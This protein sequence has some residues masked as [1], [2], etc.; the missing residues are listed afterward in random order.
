MDQS[1]R[2]ASDGCIGSGLLARHR[3]RLDDAVHAALSDAQAGEDS[4]LA[5]IGAG[6]VQDPHDPRHPR[7]HAGSVPHQ[8]PAGI[9][10]Q[11]CRPRR[12]AD[13][14][15]ERRDRPLS[16]CQGPQRAIRQHCRG[17]RDP[18][19]CRRA[20][21]RPRRRTSECGAADRGAAG[22][23]GEGAGASPELAG[24]FLVVSDRWRPY[25]ARPTPAAS[26]CQED[27]GLRSPGGRLELVPE[28]RAVEGCPG[29]ADLPS[30][31][32]SRRHGLRSPRACSRNW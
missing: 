14:R 26:A 5:G 6:L 9:A 23:R 2:R 13:R 29:T 25:R 1:R 15:G 27:R 12:H 8:F 28:A 17:P 32:Q 31:W 22:V 11:Q 20:E 10:Q 4:A 7:A 19:R 30:G 3:R 18:G 21:E 16:V 24:E